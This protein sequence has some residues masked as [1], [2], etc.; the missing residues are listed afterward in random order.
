CK[1]CIAVKGNVQ[2]FLE[3]GGVYAAVNGAHLLPG[4]RGRNR[5]RASYAY[6]QGAVEDSADLA[7]AHEGN[8][9]IGIPSLVAQRAVRGAQLQEVHAQH[10]FHRRKEAFFRGHPRNGG[11]GKEAPAV[12]FREAGRPVVT[13]V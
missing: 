3:E 8:I 2:P 6:G 10:L 12:V 9:T 13:A 11:G 4:K 5:P 7:G 1:T